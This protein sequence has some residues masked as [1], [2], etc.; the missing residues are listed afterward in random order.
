MKKCEQLNED[1]S[2]SQNTPLQNSLIHN[3]NIAATPDG[4]SP[5]NVDNHSPSCDIPEADEA[6]VLEDNENMYV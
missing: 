4:Q 5:M 1:L 6:C 3:S 2:Q